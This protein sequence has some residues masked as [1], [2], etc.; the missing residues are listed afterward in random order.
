MTAKIKDKNAGE[1]IDRSSHLM[2]KPPLKT[3]VLVIALFNDLLDAK[4]GVGI[5]PIDRERWRETEHEVLSFYNFIYY[6][7]L[8]LFKII[9][10]VQQ[11]P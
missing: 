11:G 4:I 2:L 5:N 1:I 9:L 6:I 7:F 3:V 10:S 8:P